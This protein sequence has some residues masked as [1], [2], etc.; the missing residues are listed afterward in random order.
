MMGRE[1]GEGAEAQPS[2]FVMRTP[3]SRRRFLFGSP[4]LADEWPGPEPGDVAISWRCSNLDAPLL[5]LAG[6]EISGEHNSA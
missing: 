3:P 1:K 4:V 5:E 2:I 6:G